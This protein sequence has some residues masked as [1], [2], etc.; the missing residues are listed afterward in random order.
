GTLVYAGRVGTGFDGALLEELGGL[1]APIVRE[2]APCGPPVGAAAA[3]E[4]PDTRT[5][6]WVEP[7]YVVE[8]RYREVTPDGLLRHAAFLHRRDDKSPSECIRQGTVNPELAAS[9]IPQ[10]T[11][12]AEPPAPPIPH[13]ASRIIQFSNLK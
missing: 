3:T 13:P 10:P 5:T 12:R 1:L 6:T 11:A 7:R 9:R 2:D 8:V 4:I